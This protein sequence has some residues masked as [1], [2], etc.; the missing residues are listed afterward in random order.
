MLKKDVDNGLNWVQKQYIEMA[1]KF[2][3]KR[4][5]SE[6]GKQVIEMLEFLKNPNKF[7]NTTGKS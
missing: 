2:G 7:K 5:D 4:E 3:F 1:E 6:E